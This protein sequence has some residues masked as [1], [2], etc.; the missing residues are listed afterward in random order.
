MY[1]K[2][3]SN[4]APVVRFGPS[5]NSM[6]VPTDYATLTSWSTHPWEADVSSDA[7]LVEGSSQVISRQAISFFFVI[8]ILTVES[9]GW[10]ASEWRH[11][12]G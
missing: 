5:P 2:I 10:A 11:A 4:Y 8:G 1:E 3:P 12:H 7:W 6:A 9:G